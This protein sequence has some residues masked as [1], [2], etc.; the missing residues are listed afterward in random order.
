ME[1]NW[2]FADCNGDGYRAVA[3]AARVRQRGHVLLRLEQEG[4]AQD[5]AAHRAARLLRPPQQ[6][7]RNP[8]AQRGSGASRQFLSTRLLIMLTCMQSCHQ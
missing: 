3:A 4:V 5:Q 7:R 2:P 6:L 1:L 8:H